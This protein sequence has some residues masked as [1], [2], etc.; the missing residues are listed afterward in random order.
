[1]VINIYI[2]FFDYLLFLDKQ[3]K[4][5]EISQIVEQNFILLASD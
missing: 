1:M 4:K 2:Y 5:P 3:K